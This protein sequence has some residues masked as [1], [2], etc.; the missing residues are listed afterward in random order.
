MDTHIATV[1]QAPKPP[2]RHL[3]PVLYILG[4]VVFLAILV[5]LIV[6]IFR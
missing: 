2:A 3:N 1:P 6:V 5:T 4:F